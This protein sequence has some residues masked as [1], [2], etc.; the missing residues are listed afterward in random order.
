MA[1]HI[2]DF[3]KTGRGK[4]VRPSFLSSV[5][6]C[7]GSIFLKIFLRQLVWVGSCEAAKISFSLGR[8]VR[9]RDWLSS[10][11]VPTLKMCEQSIHLCLPWSQKVKLFS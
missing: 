3:L 7:A 9:C 4:E 10:T 6:S 11:S 5:I 2:C 8:N 1:E